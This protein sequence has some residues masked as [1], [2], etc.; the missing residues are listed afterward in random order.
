MLGFH[1]GD[2]CN[3]FMEAAS[4]ILGARVHEEYSLVYHRDDSTLV[5]PVPISVDFHQLETDAQSSEVSEEMERLVAE[6]GLEDK[7]VGLG[8]D[9]I[10][11]TKGIPHRIRAI[12]R[13]FERNPQYIGRVVFI[14]AG[15]MSRTNI[16][17]PAVGGPDRAPAGRCE[18]PFRHRR[19]AAHHVHA[20]RP[21]QPDPDG[22][23][24]A[25]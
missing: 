9:R 5:R 20:D 24:A 6:W 14:Q 2:H 1:I 12:G 22:P 17:L 19:L 13:F 25:G 10:D 3:N 16:R 4:R 15:V 11:Y 23:A 7:I 8:I 21:A 18:Q